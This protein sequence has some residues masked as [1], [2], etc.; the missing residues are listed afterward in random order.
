MKLSPRSEMVWLVNSGDTGA[1][2]A[3]VTAS[4]ED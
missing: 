2:G 4:I 1:S 3:I